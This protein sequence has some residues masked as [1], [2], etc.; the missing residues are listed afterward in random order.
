MEE[1]VY[2]VSYKNDPYHHY[3]YVCG[4]NESGMYASC[5]VYPIDDGEFLQ[6]GVTRMISASVFEGEVE[7]DPREA[8]RV[9]AA[10]DRKRPAH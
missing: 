10:V 8:G 7:V 1:K 2:Y 4:P 5:Q 6:P 9:I 3:R